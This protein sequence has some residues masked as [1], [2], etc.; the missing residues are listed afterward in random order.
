MKVFIATAAAVLLAGSAAHAGQTAYM[1]PGGTT[2]QG[3]TGGIA[4]SPSALNV[5][6]YPIYDRRGS[7]VPTMAAAAGDVKIG[8]AVY[9][10][11]GSLIGKVAYADGSVAVVQSQK[12]ALRL[13]IYAFGT[14]QN[15]LLLRLSRYQFERLAAKYGAK[16]DS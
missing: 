12:S 10:D 2:A 7:R 8:S 6:V 11:A 13:P 9:S 16:N 14:Q 1:P 15:R 3:A 4:M 5:G